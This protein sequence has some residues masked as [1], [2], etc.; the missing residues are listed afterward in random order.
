MGLIGC[1][2][3][4]S[5]FI[6]T[7]IMFKGEESWR[8]TS[9]DIKLRMEMEANSRIET[10]LK[11][12]KEQ[13]WNKRKKWLERGRASDARTPLEGGTRLTILKIS[14]VYHNLSSKLKIRQREGI[15]SREH[16]QERTLTWWSNIVYITPNIQPFYKSRRT[17]FISGVSGLFAKTQ[18]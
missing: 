8:I 13:R 7:N 5:I 18:S 1:T 14:G 10:C 15:L 2:E 12:Q 3:T 4:R 16:S 17:S 6:S 9:L 11:E